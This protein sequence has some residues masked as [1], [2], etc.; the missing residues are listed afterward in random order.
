MGV[1]SGGLHE[2]RAR[3]GARSL[4]PLLSTVLVALWAALTEDLLSMATSS[5][6]CAIGFEEGEAGGVQSSMVCETFDK[7][8]DAAKLRSRDITS[9]RP[10]T[11]RTPPSSSPQAPRLEVQSGRRMPDSSNSQ[12][13]KRI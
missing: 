2:C 6:R 5:P 3:S 10:R 4:P 13:E 8:S 1:D 9:T 7:A 12:H 11:D